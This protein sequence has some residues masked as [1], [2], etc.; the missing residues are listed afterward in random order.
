MLISNR[1]QM[2]DFGKRIIFRMPEFN[3]WEIGER[4]LKLHMHFNYEGVSKMSTAG[5][6]L[7]RY[8]PEHAND[9]I[10]EGRKMGLR[11]NLSPVVDTSD[12]GRDPSMFYVYRME[13]IVTLDQ[14]D[15]HN[16]IVLSNLLKRFH[17]KTEKGALWQYTVCV[18]CV[19]EA[20]AAIAMEM[21]GD[22]YRGQIKQA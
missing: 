20:Q 9:V 2:P 4:D 17:C 18:I 8:V 3:D 10:A 6:Y 16:E 13:F 15:R 22:M 1:V 7:W 11:M 21:I 19:G 12:L 14:S 5:H